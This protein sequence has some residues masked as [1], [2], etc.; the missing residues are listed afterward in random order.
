M[1]QASVG[2]DAFASG[3]RATPSSGAPCDHA[4]EIALSTTVRLLC[5]ASYAALS[6]T[7]QST[8]GGDSD[9]PCTPSAKGW[10][11]RQAATWAESGDWGPSALPVATGTVIVEV[12]NRVPKGTSDRSGSR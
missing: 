7:E 8:F 10:V 1:C 6:D 2:C 12:P 4:P 11:T 9:E 5:F 3:T